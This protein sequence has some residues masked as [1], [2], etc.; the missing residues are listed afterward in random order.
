MPPRSHAVE[1]IRVAD[2]LAAPAARDLVAPEEPLEIRVAGETLALT[3]RTPGDDRELALG[4]LFAEGF[5]TSIDDVSGVAHCGRADDPAYGNTLEITAAPG[6]YIDVD[7]RSPA[8]RG[9]LTTAACGVCGR[10]TL[11]DLLAARAPVAAG[12]TVAAKTLSACVRALRQH[13][14]LFD[15]TGGCH[16]AGLFTF[17]G[18]HVVTYEDV[19]R[20]N[21]VDKVVGSRLR[22]RGLPLASHVLVV[23]GR[24]G[25]EIIQKAHAAGIPVVASVSAPSSL[26]VDLAV[27]A[28][29]TLA[30]FARGDNFTLYAGAERVQG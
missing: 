28:H 6:V 19:G 18:A 26:A 23:S 11:D 1:V 14:R 9:T 25:F 21:A 5:I 12:A 8:R 7:A 17:E 10:R 3:M 15:E 16:G 4:F 27:R 30:G 29:V 22:A 20:H 2:G 24:A 13:Q